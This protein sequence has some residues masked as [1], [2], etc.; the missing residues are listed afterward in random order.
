MQG[1]EGRG[2]G[3]T[4]LGG[5]VPWLL[6]VMVING[7]VCVRSIVESVLHMQDMDI[8]LRFRRQVLPH[9][10]RSIADIYLETYS[11]VIEQT[12]GVSEVIAVV[13]AGR[14]LVRT[15][16]VAAKVGEEVERITVRQIWR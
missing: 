11:G 14:T 10:H 15:T 9:Q 8:R 4:T 6:F 2:N 12:D 5:R 1:R 7:D 3:E 13:D 16:H